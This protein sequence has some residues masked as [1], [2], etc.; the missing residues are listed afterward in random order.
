MMRE[1]LIKIAVENL[2]NMGLRVFRANQ[3]YRGNKPDLAIVYP[4]KEKY[5]L[6][7][8]IGDDCLIWPSPRLINKGHYAESREFCRKLYQDER[9]AAW[10][11]A[12]Y[13]DLGQGLE[14]FAYNELAGISLI[15]MRKYA[16]LIYPSGIAKEADKILKSFN[17][18][19]RS[20]DILEKFTLTLFSQT[21]TAKLADSRRF[22]QF[23][24]TN[25]EI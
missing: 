12:V 3:D 23:L 13:C 8:V 15:H 1:K 7:E 19:F 22:M 9:T 16:A 17:L 18:Q 2:Y 20:L 25:R 4:D 24:T 11:A 6:T 10:A 14:L 5:Y 21:D